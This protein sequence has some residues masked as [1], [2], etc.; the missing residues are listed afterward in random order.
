MHA[1]AASALPTTSTQV[2]LSGA[3]F[4]D[5]TGAGLRHGGLW[6]RGMSAP[7]SAGGDVAATHTV[8]EAGPNLAYP[9][10]WTHDYA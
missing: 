9:A 3:K 1:P 6:A 2:K 10:P 5:R 7:A 4:T 8:R